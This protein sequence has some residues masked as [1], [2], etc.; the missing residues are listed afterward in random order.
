MEIGEQF[1]QDSLNEF[2]ADDRNIY[3]TVHAVGAI[4]W[5]VARDR[6]R[7]SC[8]SALRVRR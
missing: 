8:G 6:L 3:L 5:D 4:G 7:P 1:T 2:L